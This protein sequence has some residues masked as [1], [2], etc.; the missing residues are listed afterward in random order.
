[1]N[2]NY[3]KLVTS[4]SWVVIAISGFSAIWSI[5]YPFLVK[6]F[7]DLTLDGISVRES[8]ET[9]PSGVGYI[10]N[11]IEIFAV[12]QFVVSLVALVGSLGMVKR[13]MWGLIMV[14]L[15]FF[16][17]SVLSFWFSDIET[18][19]TGIFETIMFVYSLIISLFLFGVGAILYLPPIRNQFT[20][21]STMAS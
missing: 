7:L 12:L 11:N 17:S 4:F 9:M 20:N 10:F 1:M 18:G 16:I 15:V 19:F 6:F 14:S 8:L 2:L 5:I 3:N 21:R 13:R